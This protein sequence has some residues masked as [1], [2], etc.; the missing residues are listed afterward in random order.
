MRHSEATERRRPTAERERALR[1]A[2]YARVAGA[3]EVG[4]GPL[5]GPL[6]A[7]AVI[8]PDDADLPGL[9]DSK[10]L[11][12][13]ARARFAEEIRRQA[14]AWAVFEL[15]AAEVD[16][17]GPYKGALT[18]L[19]GAIRALDPPADY[20]LIDAR[21]LPALALPQES[22]IRG[23]GTHLCIAAASVVAKV[24]RDGLMDALDA[25]FPGYGLAR[26]KGYGTAEHLAALERL[27]P[28]PEHRRSYAPV[29][30]LVAPE[31]TLF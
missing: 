5:A 26:H 27:G 1:A 2:G 18:A 7:A 24:H 8:L 29:R 23:D 11:T 20:A 12:A 19:A 10:K 9:D 25:V 14:V 15:P 28:C 22:P 4:A 30:R 17:I 31:P 16:R 21:P 3:D 13:K 6:V